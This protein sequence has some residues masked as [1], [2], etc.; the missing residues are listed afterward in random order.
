M[1]QQ[2]V[3]GILRGRESIFPEDLIRA[4]EKVGGGKIR[5]EMATIGSEPAERP[6]GYDLI[7]DRISHDYPMYHV[8]LKVAAAHGAYVVP[9]PFLTAADE[10]RKSVV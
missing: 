2:K 3:L 5:A 10:D 6:L 1:E 9:N 4:V 8:L 7:Y